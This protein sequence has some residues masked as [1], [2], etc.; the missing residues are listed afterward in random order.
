[1]SYSEWTEYGYGIENSHE[2]NRKFFDYLWDNKELITR[3]TIEYVLYHDSTVDDYL[4]NAENNGTDDTDFFINPF[5]PV[6]D[7]LNAKYDT[8]GFT[9]YPSCSDT[10]QEAVLIYE[11]V[12]PWEMKDGDRSMTREKLDRIFSELA[13]TFDW[14]N[15]KPDYLN[16]RYAG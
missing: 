8:A 14:N 6:A 5:M 9:S 2:L 13:E 15:I 12:F 3:N 10:D 16:P 7:I 1:M 4:I 11:P